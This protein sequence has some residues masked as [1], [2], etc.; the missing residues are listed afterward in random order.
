MYNSKSYAR[1][2]VHVLLFVP[3]IER[4]FKPRIPILLKLYFNFF[5]FNTFVWLI[6]IFFLH[7]QVFINH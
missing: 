5:I 7:L 3:S 2:F 1:F 6:L 4:G